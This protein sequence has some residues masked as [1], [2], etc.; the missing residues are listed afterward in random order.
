MLDLKD[1]SYNEVLCKYEGSRFYYLCKFNHVENLED[2]YNLYLKY[3]GKEKTMLDRD[4]HNLL[5]R[6][7]L[8]NIRGGF[9][10]IYEIKKYSNDNLKYN[11]TLNK[12]DV[13]LFDTPTSYSIS[14]TYEDIKK[15]RMDS[16]KYDISH[17]MINGF[18]YLRF[19]SNKIGPDRLLLV[20][21]AI[22]MYTEQIERQALLTDDRNC[23]LF[24]F[25]KVEKDRIIHKNLK[26]IILY[27]LNNSNSFV[28]GNVNDFKYDR[29]ISAINN[30]NKIDR[31]IRN[32]VTNYISNYVTLDEANDIDRGN[33]KVLNRFIR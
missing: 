12:G 3:D 23:N 16:I 18:N 21:D 19:I 33:V 31:Q 25:N 24:T 22:D 32:M 29:Y 10:D 17:S 13:L 7:K 28:W 27:L 9:A 20:R 2:V 4:F 15:M 26:E 11:D 5:K 1:V 30:D 14:G 6:L 8:T